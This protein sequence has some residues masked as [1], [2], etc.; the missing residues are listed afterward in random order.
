M[1]MKKKLLVPLLTVVLVGSVGLSPAS[2]AGSRTWVCDQYHTSVTGSSDSKS[3][4]TSKR[5]AQCGSVQVRAHYSRGQVPGYVT[6]WDRAGFVVITSPGQV[7]AG[8]HK[9]S[10][11]QK[12]YGGTINT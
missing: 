3:A 11:P 8:N 4:T 10:A 9:V 7:V 5:F 6:S 2:A 12:G 1:N